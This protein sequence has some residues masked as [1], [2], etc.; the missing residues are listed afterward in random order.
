VAIVRLYTGDDGESHFEELD[1]A[2]HPELGNVQQNKGISFRSSEAGHFSDWHHAPR[3]QYVIT[4]TGEMEIAVGD[5][6]LRH[7]GPGDVLL[8]QDLTGRGHTTRIVGNQPRTSATIP[9]ED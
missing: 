8:A 2:A 6:T 1:L 3:R 4:L 5:G 7:F 9:L